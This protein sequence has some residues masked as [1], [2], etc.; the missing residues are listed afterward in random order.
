MGEPKSVISTTGVEI[1]I[2]S[3]HPATFDECVWVRSLVLFVRTKKS[4]NLEHVWGLLFHSARVPCPAGRFG[5][6]TG[7]SS[8][9]CDGPCLH[10]YYCPPGSTSP[11][12]FRCHEA[13]DGCVGA[14][15]SDCE[16]CAPGYVM[17]GGECVLC[18]SCGA[19]DLDA[20]QPCFAKTRTKQVQC[21]AGSYCTG[22]VVQGLCAAGFFCPAGSTVPT[23]EECGGSGA[24]YC[25]AGTASR[26]TVPAGSYSTPETGS[27]LR[28]E[29]A[30]ACPTGFTCHQGWVVA[31]SCT[32]H[33]A[34]SSAGSGWRA[35]DPAGDLTAF[36]VVWCDQ[37]TAGG[38]WIGVYAATGTDGE[39]PIM[40]DSIG[41]A[42]PTASSPTSS[43]YSLPFS[44]FAA[45]SETATA[46]LIWRSD[47]Q[48]LRI[49]APPLQ[50]GATASDAT[51][52]VEVTV[53]APSPTGEVT[54]QAYMGYKRSGIEEG[55]DFYVSAVPF[56]TINTSSPSWCSNV[57]FYSASSDVADG[58]A[59]YHAGATLGSWTP[60]PPTGC[61]T[62][63]GNGMAFVLSL[64]L[65][66]VHYPHS[67]CRAHLDA[68]PLAQSGPYLLTTSA[69]AAEVYCDM[70]RSSDGGGWTILYSATGA[71]GEAPVT[72]DTS[73]AGTDP[74]ATPQQHYNLPR[75][76]KMAIAQAAAE[77]LFWRSPTSWVHVN[78]SLFG[79]GDT[80]ISD[81]ATHDVA[82]ELR[83][84]AGDVQV[85]RM[86]WA[87]GGSSIASGG[88]LGLILGP[89]PSFLRQDSAAAMLNPVCKN[90]LIFSSSSEASDGDHGYDA[91]AEWSTWAQ[92][93]TACGDGS[94]GG[95][96]TFR[97]A[98][99]DRPPIC[100]AGFALS[101]TSQRCF[102]VLQELGAVTAS[103]AAALCAA[104]NS[105]LAT[106]DSAAENAAVLSLLSKSHVVNSRVWLGL[107]DES[108]EG[109]SMWKEG[110]APLFENWR[111]GDTGIARDDSMDC[112]VLLSDGGNW[113]GASCLNETAIPLCSRPVGR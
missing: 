40:A 73:T 8:P 110:S 108:V 58:D 13:C 30:A 20:G 105:V 100:P 14:T 39:A 52:E 11:D 19:S 24:T 63:E 16:A 49:E 18:G 4:H 35:I 25:P 72:S 12:A 54:T 70:D 87:A 15:A 42:A 29:G 10:G 22:G 94:E 78:A 17:A 107:S 103:W 23:V 113:T 66:V 61:A 84:N 99:R 56:A 111:T 92:T 43:F 76:L 67:S 75:S 64:R 98:V 37:T 112:T 90:M 1:W 59:A 71:D 38:Q 101:P 102:G 34:R 96:L 104:E 106:V 79:D 26:L 77:T 74:L 81:G 36:Q 88:D 21:A 46:T 2:H 28:R 27:P 7:L 31:K 6:S 82:V 83:T 97:V 48:W 85:G 3:T 50:S 5:S 68:N 80:P 109:V 53:W 93:S 91:A 62:S 51:A 33:L 9:E 57:Y 89:E 47:D 69:G 65:L 60:S 55:G 41:V 86:G 45:L 95:N 32:E 44:M